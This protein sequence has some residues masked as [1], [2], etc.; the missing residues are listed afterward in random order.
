MKFSII[1]F[2]TLV[3][4][5]NAVLL[6]QEKTI[7][8]INK[9]FDDEGY[10]LFAPQSNKFTYLINRSGEKVHSWPSRFVPGMT[11][12]LSSDGSLFRAGRVTDATYINSGGAGGIIEQIDWDGRVVWEFH[13]SSSSVRQHHDFEILPN[14]NILVLA[15]EKKTIEE[16]VEAGRD[17]A[18]LG[19]D[20]LWPDHLVEIER[21]GSSGGKVVWEWHVWDH[22]VQDFDQTRQNYG[23][24][25]NPAR[26]NIN[27]FQNKLAD[28]IHGNAI[29]YNPYLDQI[30][31]SSR[32]FNELWIIDHSTT[33]E[34]A[35]TNKGGRSGKGGDLLW[36]WG[37][38]AA[39]KNSKSQNLFGQHGIYWEGS[40][41]SSSSQIYVYNNGN[42]RSPEIYST[43]E[44][45]DIESD[46]SG[47]YPLSIEGYFGPDYFTRTF[48]PEDS[49]D[50]YAPLFSNVVK[51]EDNRMLVCVGPRGTFIEY[52]ED[53]EELWK[54]ISPVTESGRIMVQG[55]SIGDHQASI[56]SVFSVQ[57][58]PSNFSGF[59]GKD[60]SPKGPLEE[61]ITSAFSQKEAIGIFPNP[62]RNHL[63]I[64]SEVD[65]IIIND[66]SGQQVLDIRNPPSRLDLS[67][68]TPG[69][70]LCQ[71]N[72]EVTLKLI[73]LK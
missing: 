52:D 50:I 64:D 8:L 62:A 14:G 36:R 49:L 32:A 13:Y 15:W 38:P 37:N 25:G 12:Y 20:Q 59:Q 29:E 51:T 53:G 16:A 23:D 24:T 6:A 9:Q 54:Y 57:F 39:Y 30:M 28:W 35:R 61:V 55:E 33:T 67:E 10:I 47:N 72:N 42:G 60:L 4:A 71:L 17:P 7:G 31:I 5:G 65:Q 56:N 19:T 18:S 44:T 63:F 58:Y 34:E 40:E 3:L 45:I 66:L 73:L 43:I 2:L 21:E 11:A 41:S 69:I 27:H 22:L 48:I 26:I 46:A 1:I 68:L 70:Y